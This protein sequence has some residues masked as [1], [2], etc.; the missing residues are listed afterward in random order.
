MS[1]QCDL[2]GKSFKRKNQ[3]HSCKNYSVDEYLAGRAAWQ[4][5]LYQLILKQVQ[6]FGVFTITASSSEIMFRKDAVFMAVRFY[7]TKL[8]VIFYLDHPD[9]EPPVVAITDVSKN[10]VLHQVDITSY[11]HINDRLIFLLRQAFDLF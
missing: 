4:L 2:C 5:E 10:R 1:W 11:T 6:Q 7:K 3:S 9:Y 8:A